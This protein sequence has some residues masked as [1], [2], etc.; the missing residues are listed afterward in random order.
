MK[1]KS[2]LSQVSSKMWEVSTTPFTS[3]VWSFFHSSKVPFTF[4]RSLLNFSNLNLNYLQAV[5]HLRVEDLTR[6]IS[7]NQIQVSTIQVMLRLTNLKMIMRKLQTVIYKEVIAQLLQ[8][9]AFKRSKSILAKRASR[10]FLSLW[11]TLCKYI[12]IADRSFGSHVET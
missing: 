9:L 2:I 8:W 3:W 1:D 4:L 7:L 6:S 5:I 12:W 11:L 10:I